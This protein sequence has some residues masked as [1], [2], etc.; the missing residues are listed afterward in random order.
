M[1]HCDDPGEKV[2]D[3]SF[4]AT[5]AVPT[6]GIKIVLKGY[7]SVVL[8]KPRTFLFDGSNCFVKTQLDFDVICKT[9]RN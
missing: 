8:R 1:S 4:N 9:I 2:K 7:V 6:C 5:K 3:T